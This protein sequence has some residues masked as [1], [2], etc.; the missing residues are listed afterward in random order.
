M[1]D[2]PIIFNTLKKWIKIFFIIIGVWSFL[3]IIL[4]FTRLPYDI[5][6][7]LGTKN[8]EYKFKPDYIIF[9]GGSGMPSGDNLMRLYY[10]ATLSKKFSGAK[11]IIAQYF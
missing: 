2:K 8:S 6:V 7:W 5:Q 4:A 11:V 9:L 10:T 3:L 1:K